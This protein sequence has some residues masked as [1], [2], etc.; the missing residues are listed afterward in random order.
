MTS[1]EVTIPGGTLKHFG[2]KSAGQEG[3]VGDVRS[4]LLADLFRRLLTDADT[5]VVVQLVEDGDHDAD[6]VF[7]L[8]VTGSLRLTGHELRNLRSAVP[9]MQVDSPV[10]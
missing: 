6:K 5:Q 9:S 10:G 1:S 3:D 4:P 7:D 2:V 8:E